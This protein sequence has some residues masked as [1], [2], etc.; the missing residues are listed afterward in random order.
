MDAG[1]VVSSCT[2]GQFLRAKG[3]VFEQDSDLC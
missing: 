2:F 3:T 1:Q